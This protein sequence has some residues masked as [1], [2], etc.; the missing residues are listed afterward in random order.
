[1]TYDGF[2]HYTYDA[3]GNVTAVTGNAAATY[4]YNALNQ[5]V[6][7][8]V[9]TA[10]T[11]FVFNASGQRVSEWNGSTRLPLKGKYYWGGKPVAYYTTA[12]GGGAG[13]HFEHTDWL[14]TERL[15]TTYNSA[16]NP[17]YAVDLNDSREGTAT[18]IG[19]NSAS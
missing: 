3:E 12:S 18:V 4:V 5:R 14:G 13:L 6:R 10:T 7:T 11:E 17:T 16:S 19:I 2:N 1:M 8:V 15:R 9:G